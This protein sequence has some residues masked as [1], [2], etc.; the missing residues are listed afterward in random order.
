VIFFIVN[1]G[2]GVEDTDGWYRWMCGG[3]GGFNA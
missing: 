2:R 1:S 3:C